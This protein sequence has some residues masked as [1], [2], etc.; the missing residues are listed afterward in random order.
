[1][2]KGRM[3]GFASA[4]MVLAPAAPASELDVVWQTF[5][6]PPMY[7]S[8]GP[9]AGQGFMD[10]QL[11]T[12][13]GYL[14]DLRHK[15]ADMTISR[16]WH[17]VEHQDA[18]CILGVRKTPEREKI[19]LFSHLLSVA[20]GSRLVVAAGRLPEVTSLLGSD[21]AID[22]DR[23]AAR[24][25]LRGGYIGRRDY[26]AG[27]SQFLQD[28]SR[29]TPME[30]VPNERQLFRLLEAQRIDFFFSYPSEVEYRRAD[31]GET[32]DFS[33]LPIHDDQGAV[34][35]YIACSN[36]PAGQKIIE[37]VNRVLD[38]PET[39]AALQASR[40]SWMRAASLR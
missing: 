13:I 17:E 30:V 2:N 24:T 8:E 22:L 6:C 34:G 1:M 16:A 7:I 5:D 32:A 18:A 27:V 31:S 38:E 26:G 20:R 37:Q 35:S 9:S 36:T 11:R 25:D 14:P 28:P 23:L 21:G 29:Q 33:M 4:L 15:V 19:A 10:R 3:V 39:Y 12:L 40:D